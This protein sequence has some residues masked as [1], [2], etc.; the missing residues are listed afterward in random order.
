MPDLDEQLGKMARQAA[1]SNDPYAVAEFAMAAMNAGKTDLARHAVAD[2]QKCARNE[3]GTAYWDLQTNTPFHGWGRAGRI[4]TTALVVA[5]LAKWRETNASDPEL[6]ALIGRGVLFLFRNAGPDG[7]WLTSQSTVQALNAL[8]SLWQGIDR[9]ERIPM[10]LS[11]NNGP[12]QHFALDAAGSAHLPITVD[13]S[14]F[15]H[16]G[17]VN[18][19]SFSDETEIQV[20]T[21]A[22]WY[23]PWSKP[24][25]A[26][27][28]QFGATCTPAALEINQLSEC[29]V[30]IRRTSFRGYGMLIGD[31][32]LPP[33]AEVDRGSLTALVEKGTID[34]FEIAPD[35]VVIYV[36]P[37]AAGAHFRFGFR[38]RFAMRAK[39]A[40][41]ML[42]DY[43]N[44]DERAVI[45]P[46]EYDVK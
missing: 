40:Q 41:S 44:P 19:V 18:R 34:S 36:W 15:V 42:Y 5:A 45:R 12:P 32:G 7:A 1:Q 6:T 28:L 38:P 37:Q 8:L 26:K 11:V 13:I 22:S 25:N 43:Y 29:D 16:A 30:S 31:I 2:L 39:A 24:E 17:A 20:Q 23:E 3:Q 10:T 4:E 33:G 9:R 14:R 35:H 21:A 46:I 27:T